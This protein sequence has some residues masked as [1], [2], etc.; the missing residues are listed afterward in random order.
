MSHRFNKMKDNSKIETNGGGENG[1]RLEV[2]VS[3]PEKKIKV[4]QTYSV[5]HMKVLWC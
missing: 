2:L 4:S 1:D 5:V 3:L